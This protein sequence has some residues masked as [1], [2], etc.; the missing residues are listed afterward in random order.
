MLQPSWAEERKQELSFRFRIHQEFRTQTFHRQ[1]ITAVPF[2][3]RF[4]TMMSTM[5]TNPGTHALMQYNPLS[6]SQR[7][8]SIDKRLVPGNYHG[9]P[10]LRTPFS[11]EAWQCR[12]WSFEVP[13]HSAASSI[14]L[15]LI[16]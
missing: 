4:G 11:Q 7:L 16:S 12:D 3:G 5:R 9:W 8:P 1:C 14:L 10:L 13:G 6:A 15:C 2:K